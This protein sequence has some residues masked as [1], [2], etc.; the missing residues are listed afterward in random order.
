[1]TD[2]TAPPVLETD[3][4]LLEA[5]T[6]IPPGLLEQ[7]RSLKKENFILSRQLKRLQDTIERNKAL[8]LAETNLAAMRTAEQLK[9]ETY[10]KLL[11]G[12]S[13]DIII[14]FNPNGSFAYCTDAFLK[15]ANIASFS[16]INGRHY[17]EVFDR[18]TDAA[19]AEKLQRIFQDAVRD[20]KPVSMEEVFD[21]AGSG[22]P[23]RYALHFNPMNDDKGHNEGAMLLLHD[24][25]EVL[26]AKEE[27]ER[28]SSAKS[29]FLA[30]MS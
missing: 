27:A 25:E 28:A 22:K 11:L 2:T 18:F 3:F 17:R 20:Y 8:A 9:R 1:M 12:N 10:M 13:P 29:E 14:L 26:S 16:L 5:G 6:P 15:L 19:F 4:S 24:I 21:I 7:L 23:R 30:N